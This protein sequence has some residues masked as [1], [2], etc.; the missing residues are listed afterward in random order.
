MIW[1]RA[2]DVQKKRK[3]VLTKPLKE[4]QDKPEEFKASMTELKTRWGKFFYINYSEEAF[5]IEVIFK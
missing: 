4:G 3:F 2:S 5:P 1:G